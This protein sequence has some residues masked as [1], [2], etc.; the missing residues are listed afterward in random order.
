ML[1][2]S[3]TLLFIAMLS[4]TCFAE[5]LSADQRRALDSKYGKGIVWTKEVSKI[6]DMDISNATASSTGGF[7][8]RLPIIL[9]AVS[10]VPPRDYRV[11]INGSEYEATEASKYGV[12]PGAVDIVV[13]RSGRPQCVFKLNVEN[14][15]KIDCELK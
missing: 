6:F 9:L 7:V 11:R 2:S 14:D 3:L 4:S 15:T 12:M 13:V 5:R 10:P 8:K 1:R